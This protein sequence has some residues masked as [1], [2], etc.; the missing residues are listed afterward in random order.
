MAYSL[1]AA[2]NNL[3]FRL[4]VSST[5]TK[6]SSISNV[7]PTLSSAQV[8]SNATPIINAVKQYNAFDYDIESI[9]VV[10]TDTVIEE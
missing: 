8:L 10:H 5:S 9:R 1:Q 7:K 2:S 6:T 4:Q 3:Q